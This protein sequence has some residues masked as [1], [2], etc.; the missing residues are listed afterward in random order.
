[1]LNPAPSTQITVLGI[2]DRPYDSAS[3]TNTALSVRAVSN[4]PAGDYLIEKNSD[5]T[6]RYPLIGGTTY[7]FKTSKTGV[8]DTYQRVTMAANSATKQ[9]LLSIASLPPAAGKGRIYG[10]LIDQVTGRLATDVTLEIT[11]LAGNLLERITSATGVFQ[12]IDLSPGLVNLAIVSGDDSGNMLV[13]IYPNGVSFVEFT[14]S[15]VI[16]ASVDVFGGLRDFDNSLVPLANLTVAGRI[17]GLFSPLIVDGGGNYTGAFESNSQL[18]IKAQ[19]SGFYD[20]YNSFPQSG[21]VDALSPFDLF[22]ISRS[23]M[24]AL[25]AAAGVQIDNAKGIIVGKTVENSFDSKVTAPTGCSGA[26]PFKSAVG[27]F[28]QDSSLDMAV[29]NCFPNSVTVFFGNASGDGT[30]AVDTTYTVGTN[31]T[32]IAAGDFDG[33]G[34]DDLVV[35]NFVS[36]NTAGDVISFSVL[37]GDKKGGFTADPLEK[38]VPDSENKGNTLADPTAVVAG[39]FD[40]DALLDIVVSYQV[41]NVVQVYLGKGDGTFTPNLDSNGNIDTEAVG[42]TPV[43]MVTG[44]FNDDGRLDLA[45]ANQG[46]DNVSVL[47]GSTGGSFTTNN[48]SPNPAVGVGPVSLISVDL[49]GDGQPDLA[50]VNQGSGTVTILTSNVGGAFS[51]LQ[52]ENNNV[53]PDIPI[54]GTPTAITWGDFN[55]DNR[56]DL[57]VSN[58]GANN[59]SVHFGDGDGQFTKSSTEVL[60]ITAPDDILAVDVDRNGLHDLFVVG[61]DLETLLGTEQAVGG[62]SVEARDLAGVA[63]GSVVYPSGGA[64][65]AADGVFVVFNVPPDLTFVRATQ[66]GAGNSMMNTFADAVSYTKIKTVTVAPFQVSVNGKAYDPVGPSPGVPV[67]NVEVEVLGMGLKNLTDSQGN[68]A[69]NLDANSEYVFNLFFEDPS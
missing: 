59:V 21:L 34:I 23:Q 63:G 35:S 8:P 40:S 26:G 60:T 14:M 54:G 15:K 41:D 48:T 30:F 37:L 2:V 22:A 45:V 7:R 65:T 46:S 9:D 66:G 4:A 39:F 42:T 32:D 20:T 68:Y 11:D 64:S 17:P 57:A 1:A 31:P 6:D 69:F 13:R 29:I 44:D 25:A 10:N 27:F 49:N 12:S 62:I 5:P 51:R 43:E 58:R 36:T 16:P 52:D 55:G 28:N 56:V 61:A 18:L 47:L 53:V 19:K 50:V 67:G 24:S 38:P 33:D 3:Q